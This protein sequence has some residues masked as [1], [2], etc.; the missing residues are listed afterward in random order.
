MLVNFFDFTSLYT[1]KSILKDALSDLCRILVSLLWRLRKDI[2]HKR[3]ELW[4][5][6]IGFFNVT[7]P[8]L[9]VCR[10]CGGYCATPARSSLHNTS[11]PSQLARE[12]TPCDFHP[13]KIKFLFSF[14]IQVTVLKNRYSY[15]R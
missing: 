3:P 13:R 10:K 8:L 14:F 2:R 12:V 6:G 15:P 1:V 4:C 7:T 11:P 5:V 9:T